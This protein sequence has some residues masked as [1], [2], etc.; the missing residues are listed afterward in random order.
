[1]K[2][3]LEAVRFGIVLYTLPYL[4]VYSP[5][6]LFEGSLLAT[7]YIFIK[8]TIGVFA[9][10][11]GAQ[12][13]F[14]EDLNWAKRLLF[15]ACSILVFWPGSLLPAMGTVLLA[16]MVIIEFKGRKMAAAS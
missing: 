14:L 12:G 4:F 2:T 3:G 13:F 6:L 8:A 9:L 1:M 7:G 10:A 5:A 16:V 11:A 15:I